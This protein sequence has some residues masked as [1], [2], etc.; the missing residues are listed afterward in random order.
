M[1]RDGTGGWRLPLSSRVLMQERRRKHADERRRL[2]GVRRALPLSTRRAAERRIVATLRRL[3][4]VARGRQVAVYLAMD[5]EVDLAPLLR[6]ARQTG[7][8]LY[9]P[10]ITH[11]RRRAIRFLPLAAD[12]T[13]TRNRF[14]IAEPLARAGRAAAPSRRGD[15]CRWSASMPAVTGWAWAA[16][17]TTAH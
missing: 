8:R 11:R 15:C 5:G 7:A 17:I 2:R 13:L 1:V 10:R 3:G 14:G 6:V 4:L 9:A 12:T 16:A